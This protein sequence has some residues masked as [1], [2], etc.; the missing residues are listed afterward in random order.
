M[1][2]LLFD[3]LSSGFAHRAFV[4]LQ[5]DDG[6]DKLRERLAMALCSLGAAA[7]ASEATPVLRAKLKG[8]VRDNTV[9]LVVDNV[10][11]AEQMDALL[12]MHWRKGSMVIVTSRNQAFNTSG[13]WRQVR[14]GVLGACPCHMLHSRSTARDRFMSSGH[15]VWLVTLQHAIDLILGCDDRCHSATAAHS[16]TV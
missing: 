7:S 8:F 3:H 15:Q 9:L 2:T 6:A 16:L 4:E 10:W 12:P 11:T 13:V 14:W 1:A 5:F